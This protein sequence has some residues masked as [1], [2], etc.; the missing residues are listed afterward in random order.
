[1]HK[2]M[3]DVLDYLMAL[4]KRGTPPHEAQA[5]LCA[6]QARH[7]Q[8]GMEL[9][10]EQEAY[11]HS[12]H[13]D[14]LLRSPAGATVSV[15]YCADRALPWPLRG[16]HRWTEANLLQVNGKV[17]TMEDGVAFLDVL[18]SEAPLMDRMVNACLIQEALAQQPI[19]L[20]DEELQIGM[21]GLR[22]RNKLYTAEQTTRWMELRGLTQDRLEEMV[23]EDLLYGRLRQRVAAGRVGAYFERHE[24]EFDTAVFARIDCADE[25]SAA[26]MRGAI[27][28]HGVAFHEAARQFFMASDMAECSMFTRLRRRDGSDALGAAIFAAAPGQIVGPIRVRDRW[29][30]AQAGSIASARLDEPT[31][32]VL[33]QIL[34]DEWL[35]E[36]RTVAKITWHWGTATQAPGVAA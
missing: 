2:A 26:R 11:D 28:E 10:W 30:I 1:M 33:E 17:L 35:A 25:A 20:T 31:R 32:A 36:R 13:Y 4:S 3:T 7:P 29:I 16:V 18:W 6:V 5:L 27:L 22:R 15:S 14:V 23:A 24:A 34:F 8:I 21:D 12:L 19:E 9:V